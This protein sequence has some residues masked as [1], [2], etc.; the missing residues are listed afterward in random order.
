[1][2][3]LHKTHDPTQALR[4][5]AV[6]WVTTI[7]LHHTRH[8]VPKPLSLIEF[9]H[10]VWALLLVLTRR[11]VYPWR[12]LA[13]KTSLT[14]SSLHQIHSAISSIYKLPHNKAVLLPSAHV[15]VASAIFA[16]AQAEME[17]SQLLQPELC[18]D[19]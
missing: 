18:L 3:G 14:R 12:L 15:L 2:F 4:T 17:T 19:T 10:S 6:P 1:M 5:T 13:T 11:A 9:Q 7:I 16:P 8:Q